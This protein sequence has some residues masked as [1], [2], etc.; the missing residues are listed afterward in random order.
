MMRPGRARVVI[1]INAS[2]HKPTG[3]TGNNGLDSR[4]GCAEHQRQLAAPRQADHAEF[5][6]V[7]NALRLKPVNRRLKVFQWNMDKVF[8]QP[9]GIKV[10]QG[11]RGKAMRGQ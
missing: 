3:R 2:L 1:T 11:K 9:L 7:N 6:T 10:G 4:K 8:W 5:V